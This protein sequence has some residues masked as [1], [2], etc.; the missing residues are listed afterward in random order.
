[1][2]APP[3]MVRI[4]TNTMANKMELPLSLLANLKIG[5]LT[6]AELALAELKIADGNMV[7]NSPFFGQFP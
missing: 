5:C 4:A 3:K 7:F 2:I 1:M 6:D